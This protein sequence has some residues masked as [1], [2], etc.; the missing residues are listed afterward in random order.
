LLPHKEEGVYTMGKTATARAADANAAA[1]ATVR[2]GVCPTCPK[3]DAQLPED[4]ETKKVALT[5]FSESTPNADEMTAVGSVM[6]NRVGHPGFRR[7]KDVSS[8]LAQPQQFDGYQSDKYK[9]AERGDLAPGDCKH[10]KEAIATAEKLKQNG[11]PAEYKKY[12]F[13]HSAQGAPPGGTQVGGSHFYTK[14]WK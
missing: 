14:F 11:V 1:K 3:C 8:V 9:R 10:L 5:I 13:F 2:G 12:T 6:H 4:E 7:A